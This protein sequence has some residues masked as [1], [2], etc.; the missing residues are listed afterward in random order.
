[1]NFVRWA[2]QADE[3]L[4]QASIPDTGLKDAPTSV[5]VFHIFFIALVA[6]L[7]LLLV[8]YIYATITNIWSG[9][10]NM[11]LSVLM[12]VAFY[13]VMLCAFICGVSLL[14]VMLSVDGSIRETYF[15]GMVD[16]VVEF[17]SGVLSATA[18]TIPSEEL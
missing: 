4:S 11:C 3:F 8:A 5:E 1:M 6:T 16:S 18:S 17:V 2:A 10:L 15:Y 12:G 7:A 14:W 9:F 13:V